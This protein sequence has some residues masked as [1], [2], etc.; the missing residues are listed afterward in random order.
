MTDFIKDDS[1]Q[2]FTSSFQNDFAKRLKSTNYQTCPIEFLASYVKTCASQSCGKCVPCRI[3]LKQVSNLLDEILDGYADLSTLD[4]LKSTAQNIYYSA[5]CALGFECAA[6]VLEALDAYKDDFNYHLYYGEC[7]ESKPVA[8][9]CAKGCP[10]HV[11]I[12][13][14]VALVGEQKYDE[15]L[16][17]IYKDNP[18]PA[19]CGLICEHPCEANCR[20]GIVDDAI[21]IRGIKRFAIENSSKNFAEKLDKLLEV[22]DGCPVKKGKTP[23]VAII[24]G[25]PAGL[26]AAFYLRKFGFAVTIFE[27]REALGGMLRYGIPEYR[28]PKETLDKEIKV[29]TDLGV[30]VKLN[31]KIGEDVKLKDI[32]AKFDC[33]FMAIGAHSDNKLGIPGEDAQGVVSAV[34]MLR[35]CGGGKPY[36]YTDKRVIVVGG[37]NVAMDCARSAM[38][39]G[40]KSVDVVYRR[41][42][43]DMTALVEEIDDTIADGCTL[44]ELMA[45]VRVLKKAGKVA[46]LQV[47]P[48][49]IGQKSRG[50]FAPR[51]ANCDPINLDADIIIVAIGQKI[52]SEIFAKDKIENNRG[53]ILCEPNGQVF[54]YLYTGG[55][56]QSGP[57][58]VINAIKAGKN[59]ALN[60]DKAFGFEHS[61]KLGFKLPNAPAKSRT[62][63]ARSEMSKKSPQ[64][65]NRNFELVENSYSLEEVL[66]EC[67]RCLRC[68][69]NGFAAF[70]K[71]GDFDD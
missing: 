58:T 5:D 62:Y 49:I 6:K 41:R 15:A 22:Q 17:V 24:G 46:G 36:D 56:C 39:C 52:E 34:E 3:G 68:S 45:P 27:A 47:Q 60:I 19:V 50:R 65:T 25:G 8:V 42:K 63:C 1:V 71:G 13:S 48:Q 26:T 70:R 16:S 30:K 66:Q 23:K 64:Q 32:K 67:S 54:D 12:P 7:G 51:P 59:V 44:R 21:N 33:I 28:L 57:S 53:R 11:D 20:R 40:A 69:S 43:V 35:A 38:R 14:Y 29:I 31:T 37:G 55:D 10:A 2:K 4:L 9:P 18:L 61:M